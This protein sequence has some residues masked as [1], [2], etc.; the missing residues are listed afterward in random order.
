M[1]Y[2]T[3]NQLYFNLKEKKCC[4]LKNSPL[5]P[6]GPRACL[7]LL[8]KN[9]F[10]FFDTWLFWF[11]SSSLINFEKFIFSQVFV[12]FTRNLFVKLFIIS[13][14]CLSNVCRLP[15]FLIIPSI[16]HFVWSIFSLILLKIYQVYYSNSLVKS[17]SSILVSSKIWSLLNI[18]YCTFSVSLISTLYYLIPSFSRFD[19]F[20]GDGHWD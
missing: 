8:D 1:F 19:L 3:V 11:S 17:L 10:N 4:V 5:K 13:F 16:C 7:Y 14:H 6:F 15:S 12:H 2:N 20:S 18:S 9:G